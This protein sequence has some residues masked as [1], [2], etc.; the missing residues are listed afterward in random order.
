MKTNYVTFLRIT[1]FCHVSTE[2]KKTIFTVIN[3]PPS[4][5]YSV[6]RLF[7]STYP[8]L[9]KQVCLKFI[10]TVR[11]LELI[12]SAN[13]T[14]CAKKRRRRRRRIFTSITIYHTGN[15][16]NLYIETIN[17]IWSLL[18]N[19]IVFHFF[20][21]ISP[22]PPSFLTNF[23]SHHFYSVGTSLI[24]VPRGFAWFRAVPLR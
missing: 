16:I 23:P 21:S 24:N 4:I 22:S 14:S 15:S 18:I 13:C 6:N 19:F 1:K 20:L 7:L 8:D 17:H 3:H 2:T 9:V 11:L 12:K 10:T 5:L